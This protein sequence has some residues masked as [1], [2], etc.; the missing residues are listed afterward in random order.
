MNKK[1][2]SCVV[3]KLWLAELEILVQNVYRCSLCLCSPLMYRQ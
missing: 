1:N 2:K 3:K